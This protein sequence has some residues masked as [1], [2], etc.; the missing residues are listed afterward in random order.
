M[1]GTFLSR[2]NLWAHGVTLVEISMNVK[3]LYKSHVTLESV[4]FSFISSFAL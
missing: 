1:S 2:S 4:T 3:P